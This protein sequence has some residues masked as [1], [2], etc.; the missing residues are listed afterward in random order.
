MTRCG[1]SGPAALATPTDVNFPLRMLALCPA[2][3]I[4]PK[5]AEDALR[6]RFSASVDIRSLS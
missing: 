3:P 5:K 1:P 6:L 2:E 4:H